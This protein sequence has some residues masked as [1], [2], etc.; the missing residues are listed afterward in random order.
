V[1]GTAAI[2]SSDSPAEAP[3]L[4]GNVRGIV[5]RDLAG[6]ATQIDLEGLYPEDVMRAL[7]EA[8]AYRQHL[9]GLSDG[10][11]I[12][13]LAAAEAM[14]AVAE[15]CLTTAFCVW[16]QDAFAWYLENTTNQQ[17]RETLRADVGAGRV[18]GGTGLSNPMKAVSEIEPLRL[19]GERVEGGYIVRGNIPYI[20]NLGADHYFGLVFSVEN[21]LVMALASCDMENVRTRQDAHFCALEGTRTWNISLRNVFVPDSQVLADPAEEFLPRIRPGFILLQVGLGIGVMRDAAA[22][23]RRLEAPLGHVNGFLDIQPAEIEDTAARLS[24]EL[25]RLSQTPHERDGAYIDAVRRLRLEAG[26]GAVKASHGALLHAG[27]RGYFRTA[28]A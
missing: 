4:L 21:R 11:G 19:K 15:T 12:D 25:A 28:R 10:G 2:A 18:L 26:D 22:E 27:A 24:E 7:G 13:V 17:L 5:Q 23:M 6:R 3:D 8:G 9:S 14:A 20:S 16:C 1:D